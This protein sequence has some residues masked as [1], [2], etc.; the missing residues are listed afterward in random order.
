MDGITRCNAILTRFE[1]VIF[2]VDY[3]NRYVAR[4]AAPHGADESPQM[5]T[6]SFHRLALANFYFNKLNKTNDIFGDIKKVNPEKDTRTQRKHRPP[7]HYTRPPD[8]GRRPLP[9]AGGFVMQTAAARRSQQ[10]SRPRLAARI[11]VETH[12]TFPFLPP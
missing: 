5:H 2:S 3:N 9:L 12:Y 11:T 7:S 8:N 10:T 4:R 6:E 1:G